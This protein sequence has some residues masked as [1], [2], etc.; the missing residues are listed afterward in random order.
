MTMNNTNDSYAFQAILLKLKKHRMKRFFIH[1]RIVIITLLTVCIASCHPGSS[2]DEDGQGSAGERDQGSNILMITRDQFQANGMEI[3]RPDS[4]RFSQEVNGNGYVRASVSGKVAISTMVPGRIMKINKTM[5]DPVRPGGVLYVLEGNEIVDLQQKY[6]AAAQSLKKLKRTYERQQSLSE[7]HITSEKELMNAESNYRR[8]LAEADGM[9]SKLEL[10]GLSPSDVRNGK[11]TS[12]ISI[13]SPIGGVITKQE[14]STGAF[15][16]PGEMLATVVDPDQLLLEMHVF[17]KELQSLST[18]LP[19]EFYAP[20]T[21]ERVWKATLSRIGGSIDKDSRTVVCLADIAREDIDELVDGMFTEFSI[22]TCE[23][24]TLAIPEYAA[25]LENDR[26]Y[27]YHLEEENDEGYAF[28][29]IPIDAGVVQRGF[30]EVLDDDLENILVE[31][32]Y[33][34]S[35]GE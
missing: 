9:R 35:G 32:S 2:S 6:A 23:R 34:I 27:V 22:I 28:R 20:D 33:L 30:I 25:V 3:G 17:Q 14:A 24:N 16:E 13:T 8:L 4:T 7:E 5:G 1:F 11:I 18:G 29:K 12:R 26:Y 19:V 15:V 31:G 21:P 10:I